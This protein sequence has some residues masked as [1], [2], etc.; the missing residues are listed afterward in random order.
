MLNLRLCFPSMEG[1]VNCMHSKL[2]LLS[3]PTYLRIAVP[4]ANLVSYDWGES[5][6]MEN[7]VFLIDLPRLPQGQP[8]QEMT[9]FGR[10]LVYF[11]KAM[12]LEQSIFES[13]SSFDFTATQDLGFVHTIGGAHDERSWQQTG[14]CGLGRV[15][16]ELGLATGSEIAVDFVT[17]SVGSLDID[18]LTRLYL[19]AQG[20]DGTTEYNWRNLNTGKV[21]SKT[22]LPERE[23]CS[24][25]QRRVEGEISNNFQIYFPTHETVTASKA[26]YAGTICFQSKWYNSPN[27]PRHAMRDCKSSRTGLLMHNKVIKSILS[28]ST[29]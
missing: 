26:G 15:V 4:T 2:M 13:V 3:H 17:S 10:D 9:R 21:R 20:D 8:P 12:G 14:Y 28:Q 16:Q 11:L 29:H 19:A 7:M 24:A 5:G 1:Q 18:F 22:S 25:H 6:D 27:F 23:R